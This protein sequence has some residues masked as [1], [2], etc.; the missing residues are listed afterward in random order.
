MKS[1]SIRGATVP[2]IEL[3]N[4][5]GISTRTLRENVQ[6]NCPVYQRGSPGVPTILNAHDWLKW[7]DERIRTESR[8]E[9]I[10]GNPVDETRERIQRAIA[11]RRELELE[12]AKGGLFHINDW[13]PFVDEVMLEIRLVFMKMA[14]RFREQIPEAQPL[15]KIAG[16]IASD[17]IATLN[18]MSKGLK[19][20]PGEAKAAEPH[21]R[22]T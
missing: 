14:E 11:E 1:K 3:A 16:F 9:K 18:Q 21:G 20:V 8:G 19:G 5:L 15:D 13:S 2:L 12:K 6:Q 22:K 17:V 4:Y 10:Q 7:H